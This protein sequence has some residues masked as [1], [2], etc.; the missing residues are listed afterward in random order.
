M[1]NRQLSVAIFGGAFV[2]LIG[3]G[4]VYAQGDPQPRSIGGQCAKE[5]GAQYRAAE[6][7]WYFYSTVGGSAQYQRFLQCIDSRTSSRTATAQSAPAP[8]S[9]R[10]HIA[11]RG[12]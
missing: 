5:V 12:S 9:R 8:A 7:R 11:R 1:L 4:S 10:H 3:S 6:N 2:F